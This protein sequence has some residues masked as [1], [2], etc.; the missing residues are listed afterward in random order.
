VSEENIIKFSSN[1]WNAGNWDVLNYNLKALQEN[2]NMRGFIG[3]IT[4]YKEG[5]LTD[6][7]AKAAEDEDVVMSLSTN[8]K[9]IL[10][11]TIELP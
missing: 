8:P 10:T 11:L 4:I 2:T 1:D 5:N 9:G 6:F 7:Y 3:N